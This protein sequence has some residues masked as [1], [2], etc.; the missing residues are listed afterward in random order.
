MHEIGHNLNLNH[1]SDSLDVYGDQSCLMGYSYSD[2]DSPA[3]CFNG[4]KSWELGWYCKGHVTIDGQSK[5]FF[6]GKLIGVNNYKLGKLRKRK[7]SSKY[8]VSVTITM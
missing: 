3:M 5:S 2:D 7:S 1:S 4:H 8:M 6:K